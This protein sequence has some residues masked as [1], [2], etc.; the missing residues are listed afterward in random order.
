MTDVVTI[1]GSCPRFPYRSDLGLVSGLSREAEDL[2]DYCEPA[3]SAGCDRN[4]RTSDG[5]TEGRSSF[6]SPT[7]RLYLSVG[8][9]V[10]GIIGSP[11]S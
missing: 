1:R 4:V 10:I 11:G 8:Q 7:G 3:E 2:V 9:P 5:P 6:I